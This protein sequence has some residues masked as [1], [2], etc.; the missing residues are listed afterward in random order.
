MEDRVKIE[1][2]FT[3]SLSSPYADQKFESRKSEIREPDGRIVFSQDDVMVPADWSQVAA[4][5]LAQKYFR[6]RGV[7]LEGGATGGENDACQVFHRMAGCWTDWGKK[8][9]YFSS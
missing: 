1:R 8:T 4:D 7:P 2:R 9:G 5:I 3:K 6:R